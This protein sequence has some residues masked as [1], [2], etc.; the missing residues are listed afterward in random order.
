MNARLVEVEELSVV[1][2]G[3]MRAV[4]GVNLTV[5]VRETMGL[6]GES[7]SG[8][9][10]LA[11]AILGL[12]PLAAGRIR[13]AGADVHL[14]SRRARLAF[15]R[16]AQMIF[17]DPLSSLSPR[18]TVRR[19]LAEPIRIHG[20]A[21]A[22][23]WPRIEAGMAS[24]GL[25]EAL[26]DKYPH[27]LSGGQAR[28]VAIAR[29]LVLAPRFVVADEPTA[30]LDVSIQ[31]DLL[32]L[33][34][35]LQERFALAYLLVSHNLSVVRRVTDRVA[36]MY[37]GEIVEAGPTPA[38]FGAP[39]HP[40]TRALLAANP[41]IDPERK[42]ERI[43]LKGEIPSSLNPPP[44]CRFHTRCPYAQSRCRIERPRLESRATGAVACH[45]PL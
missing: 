17:Q 2:E 14:Q 4:D 25:A 32:N 33:M 18:L 37:L 6:V 26:L 13:F 11:K 9:T 16:Q 3:G 15:R 30:G 12:H 43:V 8:K 23:Y 21:M 24:V 28:R 27:Q 19:L 31:G 44:G 29:A 34:A 20:L 35:D 36:V 45:F 10:T 38:V 41:I 39:A 1:F 40:Y 42:R 7:G 22:E 5:D